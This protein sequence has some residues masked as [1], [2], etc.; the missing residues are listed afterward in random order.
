MPA[1]HH[2]AH[3]E[4]NKTRWDECVSASPQFILY[5]LSWYLDVVSPN[6]EALIIEENDSYVA[7]LPIPIQHKYGISFIHQPL[8]CQFLMIFSPK[9]IDYQ[10]FVE[11]LFKNYRF[12]AKFNLAIIPSDD[13]LL[14]IKPLQTHLLDLS[15]DYQT[16]YQQYSFDRKQNL[17]RALK[18]NWQLEESQDVRP[19]IQLF[20]QNHEYQIRGGVAQKAYIILEKLF[21]EIQKRGLGKLWYATQQGQIEA[22]CWFVFSGNRVIYLFNAA[23]SVGRKGN[24]RTFLLDKFFQEHAGKNYLFDFESPT[25]EAIDQFYASFGAKTEVFWQVSWNKLPRLVNWVWEM[26][27]TFRTILENR[28]T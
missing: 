18:A 6:W 28:I 10:L 2:L 26:K 25:I 4:I 8:F 3:S 13:N 24:A 11:E 21:A 1:I 7:V 16:I 12:S 19:M 14:S 22:A 20:R 15:P 9:I 27:N 23:S 17:K 5:G